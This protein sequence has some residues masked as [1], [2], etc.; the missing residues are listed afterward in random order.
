MTASI[1]LILELSNNS[2]SYKMLPLQSTFMDFCLKKMK[3]K[4]ENSIFVIILW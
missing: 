4:M 1:F 3:F 2:E